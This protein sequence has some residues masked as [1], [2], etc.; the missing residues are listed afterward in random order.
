MQAPTQSLVDVARRRLFY[1]PFA[2]GVV[3]I[4]ILVLKFAVNTPSVDQWDM[5]PL[6]R[7]IS[8]HNLTFSQLWHQHNEHRILFPLLVLLANAYLTHWNSVS[9]MLIGLLFAAITGLLLLFMLR[10]TVRHEWLAIAAAGLIELFFFSPVQWENWLWGWQVEWF[11]CVTGSIGSLYALVRSVRSP[12]N[13]RREVLFVLAALSASIATF[14]LANGMLV[15]VVGLIVLVAYKTRW[16]LVAAW[17]SSGLLST[18]LYYHDYVSLPSPEG[19]DLT[20]VLHHPILFCEFFV[21]YFGGIVGPLNGNLRAAGIA[22][23]V[24]LA[25]LLPLSYFAWQGRQNVRAYVPWLAIIALSVL[26]GF[27]TAYGR[28]GYGI[29]A[30]LVSRY[31]AYSLLYVIGIVGVAFT[32]IGRSMGSNA[33]RLYSSS[34]AL[35][36][37]PFLILGYVEGLHGFSDQSQRLKAIS[38][39]THQATATFACL[40]LTYPSAPQVVGQGLAYIKS[41]HWAGY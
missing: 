32:L 16:A 21:A 9:E 7:S 18:V 36:C 5:V 35:V 22:G 34:V 14:C 30:A 8:A 26:A 1:L 17:V 37:L 13:R 31:T 2:A 23:A 28:L 38:A 39:C 11:M 24:L 4:L 27:V 19:A 41:R 20:V 12:S 10:D 25:A 6:F 40:E 3:F 29:Y 15:W 33:K